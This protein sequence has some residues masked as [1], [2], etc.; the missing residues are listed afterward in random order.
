MKDNSSTQVKGL[1]RDLKQI[2]TKSRN[3]GGKLS[4]LVRRR[5]SKRDRGQ[6]PS[7]HRSQKFKN[8]CQS[9]GG[10][11]YE[12]S[13]NDSSSTYGQ[14]KTFETLFEGS[15]LAKPLLALKSESQKGYSWMTNLMKT[16]LMLQFFKQVSMMQMTTQVVLAAEVKWPKF[17][18]FM[19]SSMQNSIKIKFRSILRLF[20]PLLIID[21]KNICSISRVFSWPLKTRE[22]MDFYLKLC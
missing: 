22:T 19:S 5:E 11:N 17:M 8:G 3:P 21:L 2:N 4:R 20:M 6:H 9:S 15:P 18:K 13:D 1:G 16:K 14:I 10:Q 7:Q 12:S